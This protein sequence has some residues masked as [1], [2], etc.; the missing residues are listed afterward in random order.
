[1]LAAASQP[2]AWGDDVTVSF[3]GVVPGQS[4]T[5]IVTGATGDVFDVGGYALTVDFPDGTPPAPPPSAPPPLAGASG[6]VVANS[7]DASMARATALGPIV[8]GD[9][10]NVAIAGSLAVA[11]FTFQAVQ[12]GT[13]EVSTS[14]AV[15]RVFNARGRRIVARFG[16]LHLRLIHGHAMVYVEVS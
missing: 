4:Y 11:W 1:L 2:A 3:P 13:Y 8:P 14:G 5:I 15:I 12:P 9:G 10:T 6:P 7:M 16:G